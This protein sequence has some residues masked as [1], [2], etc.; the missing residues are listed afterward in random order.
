MIMGKMLLILI[1]IKNAFVFGEIKYFFLFALPNLF[2]SSVGNPLNITFK[3][4][5]TALCAVPYNITVR[6][7]I[8]THH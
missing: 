8:I 3:P 4:Y 5:N 2:F 6:K 7:Q 1:I